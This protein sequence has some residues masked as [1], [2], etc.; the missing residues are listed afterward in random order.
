MMN[1]NEE[2]Y[3]IYTYRYGMMCNRK[4]DVVILQEIVADPLLINNK[5]F[6]I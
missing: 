3:L 2:K 1:D 4:K 6:D 5:K